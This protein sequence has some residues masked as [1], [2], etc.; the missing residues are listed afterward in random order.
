MSTHSH[1]LDVPPEIVGLLLQLAL[2]VLSVAG[3]VLLKRRFPG[4]SEKALQ[5]LQEFLVKARITQE[6]VALPEVATATRGYLALARLGGPYSAL[7]TEWFTAGRPEVVADVPVEDLCREPP[8]V[9]KVRKKYSHAVIVVPAIRIASGMY[10]DIVISCFN[11]E[12]IRAETWLGVTYS[13]G[14]AK[15]HLKIAEGSVNIKLEWLHHAPEG[16]KPQLKVIKPPLKVR[17]EVCSEK[18]LRPH[19]KPCIPVIEASR[20]GVHE[21]VYR[22]PVTKRVLVTHASGALLPEALESVIGELP[23]LLAGR[24]VTI[25]LSVKR[26]FKTIAEASTTL[27]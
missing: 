27:S 24:G 11:T 21:Q 9:I 14:F 25:K 13:E 3:Y 15:C 22:Y 2:I 8:L 18:M 17:V 26:L 12:G 1:Y 20:P 4:T 7:H 10:K 23:P 5:T 19:F 16:L 6:R